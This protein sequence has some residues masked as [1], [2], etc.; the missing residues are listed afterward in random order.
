MAAASSLSRHAPYRRRPPPPRPPAPARP[1]TPPVSVASPPAAVDDDGGLLA[2]PIAAPDSA[3]GAS[4]EAP[5]PRCSLLP[6]DLNLPAS[7]PKEPA[8]H[9][10]GGQSKRSGGVGG[11]AR[12][13][14][15]GGG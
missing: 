11:Q 12:W 14:R 15:G 2:L 9:Q 8:P 13:T 6:F 5:A 3:S 10:K 7:S 1:P 4:D